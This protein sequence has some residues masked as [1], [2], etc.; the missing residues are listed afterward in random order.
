[1]VNAIVARILFRFTKDNSLPNVAI[2]TVLTKV[3]DGNI[4]RILCR[5]IALKLHPPSKRTN[6]NH[7]TANQVFRTST[8][9]GKPYNQ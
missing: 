3:E 8:M 1:M 2:W 7:P 9:L 6:K 4:L 5:L